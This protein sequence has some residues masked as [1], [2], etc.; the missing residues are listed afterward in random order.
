MKKLHKKS[1]VN[2]NKK[3]LAFASPFHVIRGQRLFH[4]R[5]ERLVCGVY[6]RFGDK[7]V[8]CVH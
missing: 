1:Y 3:G 2:L 7:L 6:V 5:A 4:K 8:G